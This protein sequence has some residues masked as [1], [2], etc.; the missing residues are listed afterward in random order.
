MWF[1]GQNFGK[2]IT[3]HHKSLED[4]DEERKEYNNNINTG[5]TGSTGSIKSK[6][7]DST[8][9]KPEPVELSE[10]VQSKP[11]LNA[12]VTVQFKTDYQ[13]DVQ[14]E[15]RQFHEGDK[16]CVSLWRA[17]AWQKRGVAEVVEAEA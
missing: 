6:D 8:G 14:G 5:S 2:S 1:E 16:L 15:M 13:T 9:T 17:E 3:N 12:S 11:D 4:R 10:S 7:N